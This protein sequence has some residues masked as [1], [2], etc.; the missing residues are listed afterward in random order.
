MVYFLAYL[1]CCFLIAVILKK[2]GAPLYRGIVWLFFKLG[3]LLKEIILWTL[4]WGKHRD[5]SET[6]TK[7]I[8]R[9][10]ISDRD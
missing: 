10:K 2:H 8:K 4:F 3:W 9:K 1:F 7:A 5:D 6:D